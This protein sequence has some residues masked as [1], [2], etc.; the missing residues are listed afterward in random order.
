LLTNQLF[1]GIAVAGGVTA[2]AA[3]IVMLTDSGSFDH[4]AWLAYTVLVIA[5]CVRAYANRSVREP[6]HRLG[7]NG[8]LLAAGLAAAAVQALIPYIPPLATAFHATPLDARDWLLVAVVAF[9][10]AVVA[11]IARTVR[12]GRTLWVA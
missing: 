2:V 7:R 5:Q 1:G 4:A 3:L 10:P 11:E 12:R 8:F 9:A 6:I